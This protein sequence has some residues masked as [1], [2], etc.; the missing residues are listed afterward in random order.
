VQDFNGK[1]LAWNPAATR[2]YGYSEQEALTMN[3]ESIVPE[4][5]LDDYRSMMASLRS[6]QFIEAYETRRTAND[7]T[8]KSVWLNATILLN[9][10]NQAYAVA[11]TERDL[12][13][14][15]RTDEAQE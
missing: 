8:K 15:Q 10:H 9:K 1:I 3:M 5:Q 7:G 13:N 2:I 12:S 6:G 11:T 14:F 4:K